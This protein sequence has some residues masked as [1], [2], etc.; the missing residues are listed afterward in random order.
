MENTQLELTMVAMSLTKADSDRYNL[1]STVYDLSNGE[2]LL[3]EDILHVPP[4]KRAFYTAT[5]GED[6][7]FIKGELI[8]HGNIDKLSWALGTLGVCFVN[9]WQD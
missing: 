1:Q 7:K 5:L 2:Y 3:V 6:G 9:D 8:Q 4:N